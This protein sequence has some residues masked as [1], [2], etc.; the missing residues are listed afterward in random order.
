MSQLIIIAAIASNGVI[1]KDNTLPWHLP[2]DMAFFKKTT[3]GHTIVMGR[4]NFEDIGRPLPGRRN[5]VL[6]RDT[7]FKANGCEVANSFTDMLDKT[8]HDDKTFIIGGAALYEIA[9]EHASK[10]YLTRIDAEIE[11]DVYFPDLKWEDWVL[12][13]CESHQ[14][15]DKNKFAFRIEE[16]EKKKKIES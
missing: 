15:D 4:K 2:G 1:G 8:G 3:T 9:L 13:S 11:G 7:A 14:P 10:M 5:I 6:S 12:V 16:Y